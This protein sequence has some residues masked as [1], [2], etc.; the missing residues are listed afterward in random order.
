MITTKQAI[1]ERHSVRVY[2]EDIIEPSVRE[3][4]DAEALTGGAG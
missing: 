3:Q 1:M 2:K 4:L